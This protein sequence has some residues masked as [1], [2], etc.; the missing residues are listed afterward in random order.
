MYARHEISSHDAAAITRYSHIRAQ[1]G[2]F[3]ATLPQ[4][5]ISRV[6]PRPTPPRV[7]FDV[8]PHVYAEACGT[9]SVLAAFYCHQRYVASP[10]TIRGAA[11]QRATLQPRDGAAYTRSCDISR[12][13]MRHD[14]EASTHGTATVYPVLFFT[15]RY[16]RR[17]QR[18]ST[19]A[20]RRRYY[21][22][23]SRHATT[24]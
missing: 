12:F 15:R 4:D 9:Q 6:L 17:R 20:A 14:G 19:R 24:S 1:R 2:T 7:A 8:S 10:L 11:R 21:H 3:H 18:I 22:S 16:W 5:T 13:T 23:A